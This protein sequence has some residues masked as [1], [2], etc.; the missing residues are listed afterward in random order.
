MQAKRTREVRPMKG[1]VPRDKMSKKARRALAQE[2]R[3]TWTM[4]PVTRIQESG[5]AYNRKSAKMITIED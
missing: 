2:K 4:N 3:N 5:K 1:M